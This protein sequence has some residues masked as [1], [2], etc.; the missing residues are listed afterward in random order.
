MHLRMLIA[1]TTRTG[2]SLMPS[3]LIS[4]TPGQE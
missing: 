4:S 3:Q 2:P 1:V